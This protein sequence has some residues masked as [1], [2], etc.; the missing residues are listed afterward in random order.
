MKTSS[1]TKLAVLETKN[2]HL[3]QDQMQ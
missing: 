2:N 1:K 3:E